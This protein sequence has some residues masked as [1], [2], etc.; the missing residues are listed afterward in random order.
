[1]KIGNQTYLLKGMCSNGPEVG[2]GPHKSLLETS[3]N[4]KS[5]NKVVSNGTFIWSD[6]TLNI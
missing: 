6:R 5:K 2:I 3:L 1:M 4:K